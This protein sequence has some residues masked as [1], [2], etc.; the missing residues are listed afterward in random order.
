MIELLA[1]A[2]VALI[3]FAAGYHSGRTD[4]RG[5]RDSAVSRAVLVGYLTALDDH[6]DMDDEESLEALEAAIEEHA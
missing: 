2:V 3:S 4:E 6:T 1:A 5:Y